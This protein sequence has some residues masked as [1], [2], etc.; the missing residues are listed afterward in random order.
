MSLDF[1]TNAPSGQHPLYAQ[2]ELD[3]SFNIQTTENQE[4][5]DNPDHS[6]YDIFPSSSAGPFS[7]SRYRTNASSSSSL[8]PSYGVNSDGL[9]PP[10]SFNDTVP[11]F[12][13]NN[14]NPYD[15]MNGIS[16]AYSS[17]KV[18]P[19]TPSDPVGGLHNPSGFPPSIG[20]KDFPTNFADIPDRRL[21]S[22][23]SSGYHS[24]FSEDYAMGGINNGLSFPPPQ[25]Q[26][27]QE[28]LGRYPDGRFAHP[29]A[30][31]VQTHI[32]QN[33]ATDMMRSVNPHATTHSFRDTTVPGYDDMP[34]Y[35]HPSPHTDM[36]I[37]M[38]SVDETLARMKL[39]G[40]PIMGTSNDLQTFI[41]PY[42]DQYVRTHNRLAFGE[43]TIIVMSSK[44]AQKSYGTEKRFLCP[45]PTAILIGNS[46]WTDVVR[47]GEDPKPCPPRVTI[48]I[49][50]E[51]VPQEGS[52]EWTGAGGKSFDVSDPPT[53]TTYIGR[54]VG[55]QLFI[56][57]VDEK[58]KKVEALVKVTAPTSDD[59]PERVIGVFPSRP[60][61]VISKPSKKR[62]SAKNL[63]LCINH[64]STI[65]LFHRLRSQTVST[66]YLCVSGSGSSFKGSDGASL[67]GLDQRARNT[68][69]SFIARTASWDPFVMY[70]VDV[71]K[72]AGGI[73]AP[74][75]PPPQPDYPSPPPNAIPFMNNGS[76][77]PIYYNQ[78][79]VLQCLTSGVVSPV[80][81]IRKVDRQTTVVGGGLQEGAKGVADHYC[82]P[83]EVCG[84]PVSQ[85][86]KIAF[87]VY[88]HNKGPPE[89][90][91]PGVT[92]AF[93]SCM[94]EKVN[95]YRPIEGRQWNTNHGNGGHSPGLPGSPISS[96]P[97][98]ST[99]SE[100]FGQQTPV[101]S[102][103]SSPTTTDLLSND[104]G[105]VRKKRST[106]SAGNMSKPVSTKGRRR[107]SSAGSVSSGRRGS[108]SETGASSGALW[109]VDIGET[110]VWTIVGT[111]QIRYNF[112]VPPVLFDS[113]HNQ[114]NSFPIPS[115]PVTPFPGVV[116]YLPPDRAAEAPKSNCA[117]ARAM[118]SKPNPHASKM[119]TLYGEN[120]SKTDPVHVFFG[121]EPSPYVEVRCTEV[122]GCL[123][124]ENQVAKRR[125]II[126]IR[127]DGVVFPS[128]VMYP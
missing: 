126:L 70:I 18:S 75:P 22:V 51:P 73:D 83:G 31:H 26:S 8:G 97:V 112:Y 99:G 115:K 53:G 101:D 119:L 61:K 120:F 62:Q 74:P 28:R 78:T 87:E 39:Q 108:T 81:I 57:D 60:I 64:G 114:T 30:T 71:N 103:P 94:G 88:D 91:T 89:P 38:P 111:D 14:V 13:G 19:L 11:P 98:S 41:R 86:H 106:S 9:Y 77:I 55:K 33:H 125:P 10:T 6:G 1:S 122:L 24:D 58:K 82:A 4:P 42:L 113:Q 15:M 23:A 17:G 69:P 109:Q 2:P 79:V 96:T 84:D 43:R 25:L 93:L 36:S 20:N 65:S 100:Y 123:P 105:R 63:E 116:K 92:G 12:N 68:T 37:R 29:S 32:P 45:P 102:V 5:I 85:L 72:P 52:I 95:T 44:V 47:R 128:N 67:M 7:S 80:L 90:G 104:G 48:S 40:H 66:K 27:F 50:G 46:W 56:S 35:L 3:H 117:S 118:L 124:P 76:Q 121:S 127:S 34:S 107:P 21:P 110:S 54:C 59:E 16:P 49:A